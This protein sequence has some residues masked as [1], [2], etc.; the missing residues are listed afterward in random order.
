MGLQGPKLGLQVTQ[1]RTQGALAIV[2]F[3]KT[4]LIQV[5]LM[6]NFLDSVELLLSP[7]NHLLFDAPRLLIGRLALIE[8]AC[9][10]SLV[11]LVVLVETTDMR[12]KLTVH[13]VLE[14]VHIKLQIRIRC[15]V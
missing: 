13:F 10:H 14:A 6:G 1:S 11:M 8:L 2:Y 9:H 4:L 7:V 12:L 15:T 3:L 5:I